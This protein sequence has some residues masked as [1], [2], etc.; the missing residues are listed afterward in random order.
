MKFPLVILT[1]LV[2]G[3][4]FHFQ[5][6]FAHKDVQVGNITITA[7]W[8][9]EPPLLNN[10]NSLLLMFHENDTPI[11]NAMKDITVNV[12]F[13]GVTKEVNFLPSEESPGTYLS[14]IIPTQL[15]TFEL[16]LEGKLKDQNIKTQIKIEDVEDTGKLSFP[17]VENADI[18][19][20]IGSQIKPIITDINRQV[21]A[22]KNSNNET[23]HL[24]GELTNTVNE[25]K[26]DLNKIGL[27][28]FVGVAIGSAAIIL[29]SWNKFKRNN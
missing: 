2:F 1:I 11:R 3:I 17:P 5:T 4:F 19:Q 8:D 12:L 13:G 6:S 23:S 22:N 16:S 14:E 28:S 27:F 15:G 29:S 26:V 10:L 9:A 20:N 24:I 21:E 18:S 25:M 7:G